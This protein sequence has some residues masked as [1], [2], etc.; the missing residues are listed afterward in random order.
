M[1]CVYWLIL[2]LFCACAK[3]PAPSPPPLPVT[4]VSVEPQTVPAIFEFVGVGESSHVVDI[5]ARVEGYLESFNYV[6]G[7][8]VEEGQLMF[9]LDQRPFLAQV[10]HAQGELARQKAVLWNAE[11]TKNRMVPLYLQNAVSQRDLDNAIAELLTAEADVEKAQADLYQADL[12][13]GFASIEAPVNGLASQSKYRP[14]ALIL[15]GASDESLLTTVYVV[16]PIW[17]NF[18]VS[19]NDLLKLKKW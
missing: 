2:L 18:N 12:N 8:L 9:V 15:P 6:E 16:D 13:L 19:D 10:E 1:T 7:G 3:A 5:R 4:V 17:V 11:Q 14:G